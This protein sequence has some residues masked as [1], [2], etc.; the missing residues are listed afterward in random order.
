MKKTIIFDSYNNCKLDDFWESSDEIKRYK[1]FN[2]YERH[3]GDIKMFNEDDE[4]LNYSERIKE[5]KYNSKSHNF[6]TKTTFS[7]SMTYYKK[8]K[9]LM[10]WCGKENKFKDRHFYT[11]LFKYLHID[12]YIQIPNRILNAFLTKTLLTKIIS[13]KITNPEMFYKNIMQISYKITKKDNIS[14]KAFRWALTELKYISINDV[15][16]QFTNPSLTLELL[17]NGKLDESYLVLLQDTINDAI[18]L[19]KKINIQW[20][21]KRLQYEHTKMTQEINGMLIDSKNNAKLNFIDIDKINFPNSYVKLIDNEAMCFNEGKIMSHCLYNS[22]W[23]MIRK[24]EYF[25]FSID[26]PERCTLGVSHNNYYGTFHLNQIYL[27]YDRLVKDETR[28]L[29]TDWILTEEMQAFFKKNYMIDT[30]PIID[31]DDNES[32]CLVQYSEVI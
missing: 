8:T 20:S 21:Y 31:Y 4:V 16:N 13:G 1:Y 19:N 9:K 18:V 25:A 29:F 3:R 15:L 10:I 22:Y 23:D 17:M 12:W 2:K 7:F 28:K 5:L 6:Y 14:W 24:K 11:E 26:F 30:I 32:E 27:A